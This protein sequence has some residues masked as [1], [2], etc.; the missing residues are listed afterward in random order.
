[1]RAAM[2][3]RSPEWISAL[4]MIWWGVALA[5]PGD[6]MAGP[7][8]SAFDRYGL[9]EEFWAWAF[10]SM[11]AARGVALYI[12]GRW[13]KTPWV[14]M[15]GALFGAVSWM[16]VAWLLF[17]GSTLETGVYSTGTGVYLII[18]VAICSPFFARPSML[19]ITITD[20]VALG[21]LILAIGAAWRGLKGGEFARRHSPPVETVSVGS[22]VFADTM[23]MTLQTEALN[24]IADAIERR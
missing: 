18:A 20:A 4:F 10:G 3:D 14:R 23:A 5:M 2:Q 21:T 16:Q 8:F 12:N 17:A 19:G 24:R 22:T 7:S 11:G 1:M 13:P 9:T 15:T 6:T